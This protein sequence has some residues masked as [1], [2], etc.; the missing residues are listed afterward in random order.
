MEM[1]DFHGRP[2][3]LRNRRSVIERFPAIRVWNE[4]KIQ[5]QVSIYTNGFFV[6]LSVAFFVSKG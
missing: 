3:S 1:K 2:I 5:Q 6:F 4:S